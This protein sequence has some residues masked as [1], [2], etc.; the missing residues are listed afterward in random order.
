MCTK[1]PQLCLTLC[2]PV[3][4]SL[5]GTSVNGNS[6]GKNTGVEI[7]MPPSGD[8]PQPGIELMSHLL[9]WKAGSFFFFFLTTSAIWEALN[10][11]SY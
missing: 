7:A 1:L 4:Y 6:L 11:V 9:Y 5:P 2:D 10:L 8:L 3:G